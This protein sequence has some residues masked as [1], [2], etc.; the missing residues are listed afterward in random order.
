[1]FARICEDLER[2]IESFADLWR[3]IGEN[4]VHAIPTV[5]EEGQKRDFPKSIT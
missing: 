1:M 4:V 2:R 5:W 3:Y